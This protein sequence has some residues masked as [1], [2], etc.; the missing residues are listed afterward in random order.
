MRLEHIPI[1][2]GVIVGLIG[3]GFIADAVIA[4]RHAGTTERR[5]RMRAE[6]NRVGEGIVGLGTIAMATALLGRDTWRYGT[7]AILAGG[8][9]L[10]IGIILNRGFLKEAIMHRGPARRADEPVKERASTA[11]PAPQPKP[12]RPPSIERETTPA[13]VRPVPLADAPP[14]P[15]PGGSHSRIELADGTVTGER[16]KTPRGKR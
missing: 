11:P 7:L 1:I 9:L 15:T 12:R 14:P 2:L 8:G 4:D 13:V 6:R 16:R 10:L 3:L 5:R